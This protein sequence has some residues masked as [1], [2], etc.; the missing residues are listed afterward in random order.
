MHN[1]DEMRGMTGLYEFG[2]R[3]FVSRTPIHSFNVS[4]DSMR[5]NEPST[6]N[7]VTPRYKALR[8]R[9]LLSDPSM[10]KSS[11]RTLFRIAQAQ[12]NQEAMVEADSHFAELETHPNDRIVRLTKNQ[13]RL[14]L[15][16][17]HD[18]CRWK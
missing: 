4:A 12:A 16:Q 7:H 10:G 8:I 18:V 3:F 6:N 14:R 13:E 11:S 9:V 17:L 1:L 5:P 2:E 15:D